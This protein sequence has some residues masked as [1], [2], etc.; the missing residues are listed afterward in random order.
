MKD[1]LLFSEAR[2]VMT[3]RPVEGVIN[4]A[5]PV[6]VFKLLR[7]LA[8]SH[9]A[10]I[11]VEVNLGADDLIELAMP[12]SYLHFIVCI[13]SAGIEDVDLSSLKIGANVTIPEITMNQGGLDHSSVC[14]Q[15]SEHLRDYVRDQAVHTLLQVPPS[16]VDLCV[17]SHGT[18]DELNVVVHPARIAYSLLSEVTLT[19]IDMEVKIAGGRDTCLVHLDKLGAQ[20]DRVRILV[21]HFD[22]ITQELIRIRIGHIELSPCV[23]VWGQILAQFCTVRTST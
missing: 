3:C 12:H 1:Y 10:E 9:P 23:K 5:D 22:E 21:C 18:P 4:V 11:V 15:R 20:L 16:A 19:G 8:D 6:A 17:Q 13:M 14:F 2:T 7:R